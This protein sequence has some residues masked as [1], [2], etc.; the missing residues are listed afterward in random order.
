MKE[1]LTVVTRK[2]Q[3]T[4]PVEIRK[5]LGLKRGDKVALV[6]DQQ[7]ARL[8]RSGSVVE[9][10]AGALR[11]SRPPLSAE[12]MREEFEEGVAEEVVRRMN[13]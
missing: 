3:I 4:V 5:A 1:H 8:R 10:T 6:L 11:S 7:E 2:G 12:Q 9:R 13:R